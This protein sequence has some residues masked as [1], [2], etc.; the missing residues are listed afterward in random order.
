M[1]IVMLVVVFTFII[2]LDFLPLIKARQK[3]ECWIYGCIMAASFVVLVLSSLNVNIPS[4]FAPLT[5]L[6]LG[7]R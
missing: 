6:I 7:S 1:V 5:R 4:P 2:L 3:K